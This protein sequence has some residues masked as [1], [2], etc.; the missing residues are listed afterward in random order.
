MRINTDPKLNFQDVLLQPKTPPILIK[1]NNFIMELIL[2]FD[3]EIYQLQIQFDELNMD[4][5][6]GGLIKS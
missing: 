5:G 3:A 4:E 6:D 1:I 2:D